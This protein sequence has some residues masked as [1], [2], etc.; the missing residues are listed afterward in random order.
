MPLRSISLQTAVGCT[1]CTIE[2]VVVTLLG[3]KYTHKLHDDYTSGERNAL[4]PDGVP[5]TTSVLDHLD[6]V[7]L[8]LIK[9]Q[10]ICPA[11][12]VLLLNLNIPG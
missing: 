1:N 2:G 12:R 8:F 4:Y 5:C 6:T 10:S 9:T 7:N 3:E 11:I